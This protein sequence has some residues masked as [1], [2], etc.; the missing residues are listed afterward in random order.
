[1]PSQ[2]TIEVGIMSATV[3]PFEILSD[4]RGRREARFED[5]RILLDG[6][7][8]DELYFDAPCSEST[9]AE[10]SFI[11]YGVTIGI[12]FHW[13]RSQNQTFAGALKIIVEDG[14]LTAV[15]VIGV[16]DYLVSVISSEM[17]ASASLDLL[18]AH[19]V[20]S[21]SWVVSQIEHRLSEQ[22]VKVGITA[23]ETRSEDPGTLI[24]WWDHDDHKHFD[25]CADDH[26]QRYQGL[27]QALGD[28]VRIAVADT[29]GL[30]L[31]YGGTICDA[32]F[33][34]CCGGVMERFSTC[35]ED[36]DYQYL[37]PLPDTPEEGGR[38]FCD[39][40]DEAVLSQ[41]LNDYD[42][43]T[44]DF[45]RWEARYTRA[46]LSELINRRS[47]IDFG[48]IRSLEALGRGESG[49]ISRLR[50][51][52][53]KRTAVVGKELMIRRIL[54]ESHL[55]SSAFDIEWQGDILTLHGRG[56]GHGVGLC[57][58]GAAVMAHKGYNYKQ[59]LAHYYPGATIEP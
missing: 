29:W 40:D 6:E 36:K 23:P 34:K 54:S 26:C 13:E 15:N 21:R 10:P 5:G 30:V 19:A 28:N 1:M 41:I 35:W 27:T 51:S 49:R 7:T 37:Q 2:R 44:K 14:R 58:I 33:S 52:G 12:G 53:T 46:E 24:R 8:S 17:K 50:I 4:G 22:S 25:V 39:T 3:I 45:F 55:K 11:L 42:L 59:I 57:Q 31:R 9:F 32:R 38:C 16:E 18:K 48:E 20:I 56:W 43:E 47:G